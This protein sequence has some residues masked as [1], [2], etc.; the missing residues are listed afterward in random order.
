[1]DESQARQPGELSFIVILLIGAVALLWEAY[2]IEGFPSL[3]GAGIFPVLTAGVMAVSLIVLL[4]K[5]TRSRT[6][7]Q[8]EASSATEGWLVQVAPPKIIGY[9]VLCGLYVAS[10]EH[11]GFWLA[12]SSF[13]M[14]SLLLLY[15]RNLIPVAVI[16]GGVVAFI[17]IVFATIFQVYLP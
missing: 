8:Q 3:S 14:I 17:Y 11:A 13:L 7:V 9:M 4:V 16:T 1:M 5:E 12:S 6:Q 2:R 10:I 15:K